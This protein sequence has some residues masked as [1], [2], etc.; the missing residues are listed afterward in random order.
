MPCTARRVLAVLGL[1]AATVLAAAP[2]T[3]VPA[4][5][6]AMYHH[7]GPQRALADGTTDPMYHHS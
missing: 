5:P 6:V 3:L 1:A 7:S 2:A 4:A